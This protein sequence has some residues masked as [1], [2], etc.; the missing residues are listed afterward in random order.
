MRD[1]M[2]EA[3]GHVRGIEDDY[4]RGLL[5]AYI[6][7]RSTTTSRSRSL[8]AAWTCCVGR[9]GQ[10]P[11]LLPGIRLLES[12][13]RRLAAVA[14]L[15]EQVQDVSP[16]T[17]PQ[18]L[19][20]GRRVRPAPLVPAAEQGQVALALGLRGFL[21]DLSIVCVEDMPSRRLP[22]AAASLALDARDQAPGGAEDV[23]LGRRG[24]EA[25][26]LAI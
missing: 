3:L 16:R 15:L 7:G 20:R 17:L 26:R 1:A 18:F 23:L 11:H 21:E 6:Q 13:G 19:K 4:R 14:V 12:L 8:G 2:E 22:H 10:E 9:G 25:P 5:E 24:L